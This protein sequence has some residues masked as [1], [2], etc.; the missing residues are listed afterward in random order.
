M[1]IYRVSPTKGPIIIDPNQLPK[2]DNWSDLLETFNE[3]TVRSSEGIVHRFLNRVL[4]PNFVNLGT[5]PG[6]F[7]VIQSGGSFGE[8]FGEGVRLMSD[9]LDRLSKVSSTAHGK[10]TK[11][12]RSKVDEAITDADLS[13]VEALRDLFAEMKGALSDIA[14]QLRETLSKKLKKV[15]EPPP[16]PAA[17]P[18]K[19]SP[20]PGEL[21]FKD[22]ILSVYK[23]YFV[24]YFVT[25]HKLVSSEAKVHYYHVNEAKRDEL[26]L[27]YIKSKLKERGN[28]SVTIAKLPDPIKKE[29]LDIIKNVR[30][31]CFS[32]QEKLRNLGLSREQY[33]PSLEQAPRE[34]SPIPRGLPELRDELDELLGTVR[35]VEKDAT[36]KLKSDKHFE[37][38]VNKTIDKIIDRI[39]GLD[40]PSKLGS[41]FDISISPFTSKETDV[42]LRLEDL[43]KFLSEAILKVDDLIESTRISAVGRL[44]RATHQ[45]LRILDMYFNVDQFDINK[46][47]T[48]INEIK[49][50]V[51]EMKSIT[52]EKA[53]F[54]TFPVTVLRNDWIMLEEQINQL[55]AKIDDIISSKRYSEE[56]VTETRPIDLEKIAPHYDMSGTRDALLTSVTD[57]ELRTFIRNVYNTIVAVTS[58][59]GYE[60]TKLG[61]TAG[62][63]LIDFLKFLK[64]EEYV[65]PDINVDNLPLE[66]VIEEICS[67]L[68]A[69]SLVGKQELQ[70]EEE[71]SEQTS[72]V[73]VEDLED[74][75]QQYSTV[76][77]GISD[78]IASEILKGAKY[79]PSTLRKE[80]VNTFYTATKPNF[81]DELGLNK[82]TT[83]MAHEYLR[84]ALINLRVFA[85]KVVYDIL[86][87]IREQLAEQITDLVKG[88]KL[89]IY[90][91]P[92]KPQKLI[93]SLREFGATDLA[94]MI[95]KL[96]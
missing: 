67:V 71:E 29:I 48:G 82:M 78:S 86:G 90:S 39:R 38:G 52:E 70:Q 23:D 21:S 15:I 58:H 13:K 9:F 65:A 44:D 24:K 81:I 4:D 93:D 27:E 45:I 74:L 79:T 28:V 17:P 5:L 7:E 40:L 54:L 14:N 69:P 41:S 83:P 33:V 46:V 95:E 94:D 19:P 53:K 87:K 10:V 16:K 72:K 49:K 22:L 26:V 59:R 75:K 37:E 1:K 73:V 68:Q 25:L 92:V 8:G 32:I 66:N 6:F 84:V 36:E 42:F 50:I 77:R 51:S 55:K 30:N 57:P 2:P 61:P 64:N 60:V 89:G 80:L 76:I 31:I 88:I 11:L 91:F 12:L 85:D 47:V 43:D 18:V 62:G 96:V 63:I 35:T 34:V 56:V 20:K 3:Y